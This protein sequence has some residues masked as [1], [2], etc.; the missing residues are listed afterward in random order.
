M[1]QALFWWRIPSLATELS[2]FTLTIPNTNTSYPFP[3]LSFPH[4]HLPPPTLQ[5]SLL[6]CLIWGLVPPV[7]WKDHEDR[8]YHLLPS[9]YISR[10]YDRTRHSLSIHTESQKVLARRTR[11]WGKGG[12]ESRHYKQ[13]RKSQGIKNKLGVLEAKEDQGGYREVNEGMSGRGWELKR[14]QARSPRALKGTARMLDSAPNV[15]R[16]HWRVLSRRMEWPIFWM[17][18]SDF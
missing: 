15:S 13:Q 17:Q 18:S 5:H 2:S 7:E 12:V 8:E 14:G 16:S 4:D 10:I 11:C 1:G 9:S 6:I 3:L